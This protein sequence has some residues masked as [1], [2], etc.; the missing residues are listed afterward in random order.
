MSEDVTPAECLGRRVNSG[1]RA[2]RAR[3]GKAQ[4]ELFRLRPGEEG[5]SVDRLSTVG[6]IEVFVE[7]TVANSS[8]R[9]WLALRA[10]V[11]TQNGMLVVAVPVR[12]NPHHAEIRMPE[13]GGVVSETTAME[14]RALALAARAKWRERP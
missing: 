4:P 5:I 1:K 11:V 14:D 8:F 2:K 10:E 7:E 12:R 3:Q 6:D 9:G 13:E